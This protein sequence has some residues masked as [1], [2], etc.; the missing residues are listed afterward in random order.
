[1]LKLFILFVTLKTMLYTFLETYVAA[2]KPCNYIFPLF[3]A[4]LMGEVVANWVSA[5]EF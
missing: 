4:R 1:M 5:P 3:F 2:N